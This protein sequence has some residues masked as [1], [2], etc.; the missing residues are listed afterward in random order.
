MQIGDRT[1]NQI[2]SVRAFL[3]ER[4]ALLVHFNTPMSN[5][6]TGFPEDIRNA[7]TA[8]DQRL[9]FS[10]IQAGD[11]GP[12]QVERPEEANAG[13]SVGMVVDISNEGSVCSVSPH[14]GGATGSENG[15][16][17]PSEYECARSIDERTD[18][19]EWFVQNFTPVGI[20]VFLPARVYI[21]SKD[22][23]VGTTLEE[24]LA[25]FPTERAFS[26]AENGFVELD[27]AT[28]K[29]LPVTYV[30]IIPF[31]SHVSAEAL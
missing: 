23:E 26:F 31:T 14:D 1:N 11:R 28:Q 30:D 16:W 15:G 24:I 21:R 18:M 19:N 6:E 25:A 17:S 8:R 5:H 3:R 2:F 10:T 13:G 22:G 12:E 20:F 4:Q 29:W 9:C 27:R 7:M